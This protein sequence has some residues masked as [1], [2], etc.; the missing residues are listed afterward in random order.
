[1][2]NETWLG[3]NIDVAFSQQIGAAT[4]GVT[5]DKRQQANS[6]EENKL[7]QAGE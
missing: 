5:L 2:A 3:A 7:R 4:S 1:M 6:Q